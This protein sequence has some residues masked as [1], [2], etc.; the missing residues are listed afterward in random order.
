MGPFE[1]DGYCFREGALFIK[2]FKKLFED[3]IGVL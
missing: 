1:S 2:L 3:D